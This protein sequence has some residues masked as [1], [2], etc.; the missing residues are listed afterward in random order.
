[1]H[2]VYNGSM[3]NTATTNDTEFAFT[4]TAVTGIA[5]P[6]AAVPSA[7]TKFSKVCAGYY[8]LAMTSDDCYDM[9]QISRSEDGTEWILE[10]PH[11]EYESYAT[12]GDA[13]LAAY[14]HP[15]LIAHL[16]RIAAA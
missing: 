9:F 15:A 6:A 2:V 7:Q 14:D 8:Q 16:A 4:V 11:G 12:L 1:M 5:R 13:K 10:G 3:N